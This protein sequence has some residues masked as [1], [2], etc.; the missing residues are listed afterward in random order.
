MFVTHFHATL[1]D[2]DVNYRKFTRTL[3]A[4]EKMGRSNYHQLGRNVLMTQI[5]I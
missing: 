2:S 3:E 4:T 1:S 5:S